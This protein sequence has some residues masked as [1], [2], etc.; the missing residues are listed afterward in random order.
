MF[1]TNMTLS[2]RLIRSHRFV[3]CSIMTCILQLAHS[4]QDV[5]ERLREI[6]V[7]ANGKTSHRESMARKDSIPA[8][9]NPYGLHDI[10]ISNL[11]VQKP[12]ETFVD[13]M[14]ERRPSLQ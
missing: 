2:K 8:S 10:A 1:K 11:A 14:V 4:N 13:P 5:L 9:F 3:S 7:P 6:G 12:A